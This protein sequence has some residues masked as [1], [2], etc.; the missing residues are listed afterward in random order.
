MSA[1]ETLIKVKKQSKTDDLV[2][3][4]DEVTIYEK[5][6]KSEAFRDLKTS[7][8]ARKKCPL[9]ASAYD[10]DL[11]AMSLLTLAGHVIAHLESV[12]PHVLTEPMAGLSQR[13]RQKMEL[14]QNQ[15]ICVSYDSLTAYD[16][17]TMAEHVVAVYTSERETE[18][19]ILIVVR[20]NNAYVIYQGYYKEQSIVN[21]QKDYQPYVETRGQ[22]SLVISNYSIQG[23]NAYPFG[24]YVTGEHTYS[25]ML[26]NHET[27]WAFKDIDHP[28]VIPLSIGDRNQ[29]TMTKQ[30]IKTFTATLFDI[31]ER[32]ELV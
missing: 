7:Q 14:M 25:V 17:K 32:E 27:L 22:K 24:Q 28:M 23:N 5:L 19:A 13:E 30:S 1:I 10:G 6:A 21:N 2:R 4:L 26:P 9:L 11:Y 31:L 12:V 15:V 18:T 16:H 29:L 8:P 20:N 3:L